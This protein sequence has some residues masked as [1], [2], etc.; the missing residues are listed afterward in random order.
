M[1]SE[2]NFMSDFLTMFIVKS[3][4]SDFSAQCSDFLFFSR[5]YHRVPRDG[6]VPSDPGSDDSKE[7][8]ITP[9]KPHS[10]RITSVSACN[11]GRI[12]E[13]REDPFDLKVT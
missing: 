12:Q 2:Y 11:C 6:E 7:V 1:Q 4:Y 9:C 5:Q 8:E 10:S 3:I 13:H